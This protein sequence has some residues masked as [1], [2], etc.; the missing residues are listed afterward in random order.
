MIE[1]SKVRKTYPQEWT[2]YNQAQTNEKSKFQELLFELC[3][4]VEDL[5]RKPGAGRNR[6][7]LGEMIFAAVFKIYA[8]VSA[9]RFI[10]DLQEANRRGYISKTP[11]FN[12][13]FNYLELEEMTACLKQLIVETSLP[14]KAIESNFAVD[15]SGFS[16]GVYQKWVDAKWGKI[17]AEFGAKEQTI[18]KKDW[19]KVHVMCGCKT[20]IV[21]SVEVT[22]A[23]SGD[24]PQFAPLV[25]QTSKNF[26]MDT[27]CADKAYSSSKNLQLVLVK[28]AQP[29][30]DFRS[31]ATAKNRRSTSVWRR[32]YHLYMS[33]QERFYH[34]YHQRSNVETVFSMIKSKFGERLRSK[35]K[36]A[37]VNEVLCKV[38]C[39][40]LCC[41]I[42]SMYELGIEPTFFTES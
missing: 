33:N 19:L 13:I 26:V 11:H 30:I 6:L 15:S 4:S 28:G 29:Y 39:H 16:T 34:H 22:G 38:L 2:A 3:Q 1:E 5:P 23:N 17:R 7:P 42:Q 21:T 12:S 10:S 27:V 8:M 9:R 40:N 20:N 24:S 41:V 35:T 18:N 36:T 37:Q 25:E 31:N 14:L 32:M